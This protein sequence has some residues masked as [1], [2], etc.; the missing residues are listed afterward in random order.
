MTRNI[1]RLLI[2]GGA[3]VLVGFAFI[4]LAAIAQ[5][6]FS[7]LTTVRFEV[8]YQRGIT[9]EDA[10][11]VADY[12]QADYDYLSKKL[13][14]DLSHVLEV[15]IYDTRGKYL[16][17][18]KQ[19]KAWRPAIFLRGILH[20]Q[21]VTDPAAQSTIEKGLSYELSVALLEQTAGNGVP[22]WLRESFAVYHS[23]MM[24]D[25]SP[26]VGTKVSAFA[27]LDQDIQ[28]YPV[29]PRRYD[30]QFLLGQTMKHF[31][32]QFGE[33]KAFSIFK[34][35]DGAHSIEETFQKHFGVEYASIEKTW[36][37]YIASQTESFRKK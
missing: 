18:T 28:Q 1:L 13:S 36:S 6:G 16:E 24:P 33:E 35:F 17:A 7:S 23:G 27:D 5:P 30:V 31:V 4:H 14:L 3:G 22:R 32:E 9:V 15:R 26:P 29:P 2:R 37:A 19:N 34:A 8:K 10:K 21:P 11:K 20:V 12:L 25:L